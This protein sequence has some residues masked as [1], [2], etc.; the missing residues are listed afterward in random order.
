M[1]AMSAKHDPKRSTDA[2]R[3]RL[4]VRTRRDYFV[5][6]LV[7]LG[8]RDAVLLKRPW[9]PLARLLYFADAFAFLPELDY[10]LVHAINAV[11]LLSGRPYVL[12]FEDFC[13][14]VPED[15]YVG[16]LQ[17]SL[18]H[19]LLSERCV[20]LLALSEYAVR[21]FRHQSRSFA[22]RQR[23]EAKLQ[24]H[25]PAIAPRQ[26][27]PKPLQ[28]EKLKLLFVGRDF[29]RKGGPALLKAHETLRARG[30]PVE[31]TV[32]SSLGWKAN[33]AYVD[34]PSP[35]LVERETARLAQEGVIHHRSL[36]NEE[37]LRLMDEAAFFVFPTLHDTFGYV[38]LEA[39]AGATPVIASA[40]NAM[41][42]VVEDGRCGFLLPLELD[43]K[44]GRWAWTYRTREP[45][46]IDAYVQ[47]TRSLADALADRLCES[48]ESPQQYASLSAGALEKVQTKFN[49]DAARERIEG[50]YERCRERVPRW[51]A[52]VGAA[53]S[54]WRAASGGRSRPRRSSKTSS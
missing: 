33:D 7:D 22:G 15:R 30:V 54:S 36:P 5:P 42:E 34:P 50:L 24:V 4:R 8:Q 48:W 28:R 13:P 6:F 10:D 47:A 46:F 1:R 26:S 9:V 16:W 18:Q 23:L 51:R 49:V 39:L 41:P 35:E 14:R 25:Y 19:A 3:P 38:T 43:G 40:T 52:Y 44:L 31:T 29:M 37:V 27:E 21:Q 32:I 45:G 17:R 20:A 53:E 11:P 12:A 2:S